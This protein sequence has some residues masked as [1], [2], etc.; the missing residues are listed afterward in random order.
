MASSTAWQHTES[1]FAMRDLILI[2]N[3]SDADCRNVTRKLRAE[4]VNTRILPGSAP[5]EAIRAED[6]MGIIL[7]GKAVGSTLVTFDTRILQSGVPILALGDPALTML[8][9]LGGKAGDLIA[10]DGLVSFTFEHCVLN[11]GIA[12][13]ERMVCGIRHL[14]MAGCMNVICR[15]NGEVLGYAHELMPVYGMQ[16]E[17]EQ[18]DPDGA[19]MLK[20]FALGICGCSASWDDAAFLKECEEALRARCPEGKAFVAL[21][22][23]VCSAVSALI[24]CRALGKERVKCV[25][26]DTGFM[27]ERECISFLECFRDRMGLDITWIR[28]EDRFMEAVN[29]LENDSDKEQAIRRMMREILREQKESFGDIALC[30][31]GT[32][33]RDVMEN[34]Y[35]P[36]E[37]QND[38]APLSQLFLE[39]VRRI[40]DMLGMPAEYTAAQPFP[41]TGLALRIRGCVTAERL[42]TLRRADAILA[43]EIAEAGIRRLFKFFAFLLPD[44]IDASRS[45]ICLRAV[46]AGEGD[47]AYA[48]RLPWDV[49]ERV[50]ERLCAER[51][52]V[53]RVL[54]DMTPASCNREIEFC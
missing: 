16:F 44:A 23:G 38:Y 31:R 27:R 10:G 28:A 12:D 2:L 41:G 25:L 50:C 42:E 13:Q 11:D 53:C 49:P 22:G 46:H 37:D 7:A 47:S 36:L 30:V 40:G 19:L 54:Y 1:R 4:Q 26:I 14:E 3:F 5:F 18:N 17:A 51:K 20:N 24:A 45:V 34:A 21:T 15:G 48:C 39:E 43:E 35:M 32:C 6:P 8:T 29:S 33:Q 9:M 52:D